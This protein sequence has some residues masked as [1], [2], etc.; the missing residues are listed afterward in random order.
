M[1]SDGDEDEATES[2]RKGCDNGTTW[3]PAA[4]RTELTITEIRSYPPP[5]PPPP[6]TTGLDQR[7]QT[8][9]PFDHLE[10]SRMK[11]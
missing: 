5:P 3:L 9:F 1:R 11:L 7:N 10:Q 6:R 8:F 2:Q 4:W